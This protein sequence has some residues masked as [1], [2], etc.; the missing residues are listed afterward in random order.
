MGENVVF[1]IIELTHHLGVFPGLSYIRIIALT[2]RT[3]VICGVS[4]FTRHCVFQVSGESAPV[5][6]RGPNVPGEEDEQ[7]EGEGESPEDSGGA[8]PKA[9]SLAD[10]MDK[11]DISSQIKP[12][13]IQELADKNWKIRNES[14]QKVQEIIKVHAYDVL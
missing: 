1:N 10:M 14:L 3:Q 13:L 5:P 11:V 7:S 8:P 6:T 2:S 4:V 9:V 12:S